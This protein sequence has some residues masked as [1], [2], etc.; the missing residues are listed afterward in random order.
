VAIEEQLGRDRG[1]EQSKYRD[2]TADLDLLFGLEEGKALHEGA[3]PTESYVRPQME[4]MCGVLGL[5]PMPE[6]PITGIVL[7][8]S[9][10]PIG[11]QTDCLVISSLERTGT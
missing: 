5:M 7:P 3:L 1:H 4:A 6:A 11:P 8:L 10:R 9:H 2:R